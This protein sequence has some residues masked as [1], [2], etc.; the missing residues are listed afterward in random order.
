MSFMPKQIAIIGPTA[1]G[2][3]AVAIEASKKYDCVILSV[4]SLSIYKEIDIAS[5]KPTEEERSDISHFGI[6]LIYADGYFNAE[7]FSDEYQNALDYCMRNE[8]HLILVGGSSFYLKSLIEG[9]SRLPDFDES[10]KREVKDILSRGTEYAYEYLKKLDYDYALSI[11]R[12]DRYRIEKS[13]LINLGSGMNVKEYF[14]KNPPVAK[15]EDDIPIICI[16]TDREIL[17]KRIVLRTEKMIGDGL[18]DEVAYLEKRYSR[19]LTA[20]KAIGVREVLDY[21]DGK[22]SLT[23]MKE[24]IVT[25]TARLA[26]R[27]N[28]FNKSQFKM[29]ENSPLD[30]VM[31][32]IDRYF[33]YNNV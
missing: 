8:K 10:I 26:K 30:G 24:K 15:V 33:C 28:T 9:L 19:D 22:Y 5:A 18:I 3:S 29:V 16:D 17:R 27:Q 31:E 21:F 11:E 23:Q 2:K 12:S 20:M 1:S 32:Y 13:L 7:M 25:N 14:D 4:D 6:D